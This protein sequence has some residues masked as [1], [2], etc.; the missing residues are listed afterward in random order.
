MSVAS[1]WLLVQSPRHT[2]KRVQV[3]SL[4]SSVTDCVPIAGQ[5]LGRRLT[6]TRF[7]IRLH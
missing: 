5:R 3:K 6:D 1:I 2:Q 4:F 7:S